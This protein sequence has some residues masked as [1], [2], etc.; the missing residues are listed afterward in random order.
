MALIALAAIALGFQFAALQHNLDFWEA[1]SARVKA[2]C[3]TSRSDVPALP[4]SI[5]GVPALANGE[6]ECVEIGRMQP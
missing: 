5:D 2:A 3:T 6:Q 1:A 4:D